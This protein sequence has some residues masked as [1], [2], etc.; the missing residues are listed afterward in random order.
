ML[1]PAYL[2]QKLAGPLPTKD[3]GT[4]RTIRDAREYIASIGKERQERRH[5]QEVSMRVRIAPPECSGG[6]LPPSPPA[7]KA[8]AR[9]D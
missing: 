5:W 2:S 7:E 6:L 9:Q 1:R 3:G 4:L 8:T